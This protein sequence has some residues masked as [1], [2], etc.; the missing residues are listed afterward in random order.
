MKPIYLVAA[1]GALGFV[2]ASLVVVDEQQ[3]A[4]LIG[5]DAASGTQLA[6]GL[7]FRIP[8]LE[9]VQRFDGR[10]STLDIA[11]ESVLTAERKNL[12]V[13]GFGLWRIQDPVLYQQ[14]LGGDELK[15]VSNLKALMASALQANATHYALEQLISGAREELNQAVL[16]Q[17]R[18]QARS[19]GI[20]VL[21]WRLRQVEVPGAFNAEVAEHM[22]HDFEQAAQQQ[23]SETAV[24]VDKIRDEAD[25]KRR[26]AV[27]EADHQAQVLRGKADARALA[28]A[29]NSYGKNPEFFNYYRSLQVYQ[30]GFE[31]GQDA[32]V[33]KPDAELYKQ[34]A[35]QP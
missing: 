28:I 27:A 4:L 3:Q 18:E 21:D 22:R 29:A 17:V 20:A 6:P 30:N 5:K 11:S 16:Q 7:H 14:Q 9:Q 31:K 1:A 26:A 15:A 10:V 34:F 19:W 12:L 8:L 2:V 24:L 13:D 25:Q 35:A 33:L 32:L 23:R